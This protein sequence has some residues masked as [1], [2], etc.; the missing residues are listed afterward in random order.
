MTVERKLLW[1]VLVC[2]ALALLFGVLAERVTIIFIRGPVFPVEERAP[3][4]PRMKPAQLIFCTHHNEG[5][6]VRSRRGH[7]AA[8]AREAA[9]MSV[10]S[11]AASLFR[12]TAAITTTRAG[13]VSSSPAPVRTTSRDSGLMAM[14]AGGGGV[15]SAPRVS[16][17]YTGRSAPAGIKT[18]TPA[19]KGRLVEL[20][21][22]L[23]AALAKASA[24][25]GRGVVSDQQLRAGRTRRAVARRA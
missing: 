12:H 7:V 24:R 1:I 6:N 21:T 18:A 3:A 11:A 13:A 16:F 15:S 25:Q 9:E 8:D 2:A 10:S 22:G 20:K 14:G 4:A 5:M 23:R 17:A 19:T